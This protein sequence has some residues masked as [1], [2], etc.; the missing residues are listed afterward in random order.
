MTTKLRL[1]FTA[2]LHW[3]PNPRGDEATRLL[4]AFLK[5]QPPD[6][7]VL[8]GD[9]G[10]GPHFEECLQLFDGFSFLKALVPGNHDIWVETDDARGDSFQVYQ[11]HLPELCRKHRFHYLDQGPVRISE[12]GLA[13]VGSINWYDY[14]WSIELLRQN[15]PDWEKRLRTKMFS[16]GRHNDAR[17]IRWELDDPGFTSKVVTTL[18]GHLEE[19]MAVAEKVI[20]VTHHPPFFGLAFPRI[21]PPNVD[22]LLWDAFAGNQKLEDILNRHAK[23][24]AFALCG[25]THRA[26]ENTLGGIR[27]HNIGGD[28]HYKRLLI[29]D[30][31]EEI[32]EAHIFGNP[33]LRI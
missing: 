1:A 26:R 32:V 22:S 25:H 11:N 28:Y 27:G 23:R 10:S 15:L 9:V 12:A 5:K 33:E 31:P 21:E 30:W 13:L 29:L 6:L 20:V 4:I 3:G 19:A 17:F 14:T 24:I 7:L 2:D 8:A 18:E 16:R